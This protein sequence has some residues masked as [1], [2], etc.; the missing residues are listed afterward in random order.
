MPE[1]EDAD[2]ALKAGVIQVEQVLGWTL[3]WTKILFSQWS[4]QRLGLW[5]QADD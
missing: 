5:C 1:V 2:I 4:V 3:K